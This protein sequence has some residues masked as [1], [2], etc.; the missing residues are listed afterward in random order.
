[1]DP[2]AADSYLRQALLYLQQGSWNSLAGSD[3]K[4][5]HRD[6]R[7]GLLGHRE[8]CQALASMCVQVFVKFIVAFHICYE[9]V[10]ARG[11]TS[12]VVAFDIQ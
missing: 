4:C 6:L 11:K 12:V 1:M 9:Y 7:L 2:L 8:L 10:I 3:V 5:R